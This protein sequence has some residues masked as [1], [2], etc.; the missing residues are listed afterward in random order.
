MVRL[1]KGHLL[2]CYE[3]LTGDYGEY[4]DSTLPE[5]KEDD[6]AGAVVQRERSGTVYRCRT[7][8]QCYFIS[9]KALDTLFS[10]EHHVYELFGKQCVAMLIRSMYH[11]NN[12]AFFSFY[13]AFDISIMC[14]KSTWKEFEAQE[15]FEL[16]VF[17]AFLVAGECMRAEDGRTFA[18]KQILLPGKYVFARGCKILI[19]DHDPKSKSFHGLVGRT[20]ARR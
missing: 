7:N 8:V 17:M 20:R 2:G 6:Q 10:R 12:S 9:E 4:K 16:K 18:P 3:Y 15:Q 11:R 1:S 13:K 14:Q 5:E 19:L